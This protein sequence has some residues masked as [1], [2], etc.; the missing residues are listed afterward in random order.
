MFVLLCN[1]ILRL[2][3]SAILALFTSVNYRDFLC[4]NWACV[5]KDARIW[6]R[7]FANVY[8]ARR[9]SPN[10][11]MPRAKTLSHMCSYDSTDQPLDDRWSKDS[12]PLEK[13]LWWEANVPRRLWGSTTQILIFCT[14]LWQVAQYLDN[15]E[16]VVV[17]DVAVSVVDDAVVDDT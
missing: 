14:H 4:L 17:C 10:L 6:V 16:V 1:I 9:E 2:C 8:T 5:I 7:E 11:G 12:C 15:D 3:L 13:H